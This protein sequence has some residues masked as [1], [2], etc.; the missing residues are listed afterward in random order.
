MIPS[1]TMER[2]QAN[3][4]APADSMSCNAEVRYHD[5]LSHWQCFV[6]AVDSE[7]GDTMNCI[8]QVGKQLPEQVEWKLSEIKRL[9]NAEGES[10]HIDEEWRPIQ[11]CQLWKKLNEG[12]YES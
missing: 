8:I 9:Y 6:L 2:L 3:W 7:D 10:P 12:K 5:D 4:G 11:A 1:H